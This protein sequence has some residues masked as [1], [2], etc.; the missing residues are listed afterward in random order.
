MM[1]GRV[2]NDAIRVHR[3]EGGMK[4]LLIGG[5]PGVL[6]FFGQMVRFLLGQKPWRR[7]AM[8]TAGWRRLQ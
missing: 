8:Y 2:N 4:L 5:P 7:G 6:G 3:S 1:H